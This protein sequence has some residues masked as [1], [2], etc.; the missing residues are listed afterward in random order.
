MGDNR[1]CADKG[2]ASYRMAADYDR[3]RAKRRAL[4]D[5]S[6][7]VLV[8]A[9]HVT[10]RIDHV[11]KHA[12]GAAEDIVFKRHTFEDGDIVLDLDVVTDSHV[13]GDE[14]VLTENTAASDPDIGH[15]VCEMPYPG[16]KTYV[17]AF[18][19]DGCLVNEVV[20]DAWR[21]LGGDAAKFE[22]FLA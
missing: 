19:N 14:H 3:V 4:P 5:G 18:F 16:A 7:P 9:R 17:H 1:A 22:G 10:A 8:F 11:G 20:T 2:V 15:D 6:G 12:R 21:H 13:S